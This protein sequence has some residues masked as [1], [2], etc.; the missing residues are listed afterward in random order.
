M[1][2]TKKLER[3]Y[4]DSQDYDSKNFPAIKTKLSGL[5]IGWGHLRADFKTLFFWWGSTETHSSHDMSPIYEEHILASG[6]NWEA[7]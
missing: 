2:Q 5:L 3:Q 7:F 1:L 6:D 4:L